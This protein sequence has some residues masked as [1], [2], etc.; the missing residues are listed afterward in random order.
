MVE[1]DRPGKLFIG[2]LNPETDEKGLEAAFG[3][4]GRISEVLLMK[5]RETSKSRGFAR[6]YPSARDPREFAP[7][8]REYTYRDYGHSSARDDCPSR[9]Y[10]DRDGYG[11]RDRDYADHPSGGFYRDPFESYYGDLRSAL[12]VQCGWQIVLREITFSA[13]QRETKC[14]EIGVG[15]VLR[16]DRNS[17]QRKTFQRWRGSK[18]AL[19]TMSVPFRYL[20]HQRVQGDIPDFLKFYFAIVKMQTPLVMSAHIYLPVSVMGTQYPSNPLGNR[21]IRDL[22]VVQMPDFRDFG[23]KLWRRQTLG[24]K[25][26]PRPPQ[27]HSPAAAVFG[28]WWTAFTGPGRYQDE[29]GYGGSGE[30]GQY[31]VGWT[32]ENPAC[33]Q[34]QDSLHL[35]RVCRE[36]S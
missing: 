29:K 34:I 32:S 21:E 33:Q 11:G 2:G 3:K 4:Y 5:D 35:P 13:K 27:R 7:S 22:K 20:K 14:C 31:R 15:H 9:G 8:P 10:G 36:D 26:S 17:E 12:T 18:V 6:D 1:A 24:C 30:R 25:V 19:E 23:G 28:E 16:E